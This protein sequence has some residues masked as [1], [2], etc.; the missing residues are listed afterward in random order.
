MNYWKKHYEAILE[1][2]KILQKYKELEDVILILGV[3]ELDDASKIVVKK[4]LQ[5]QNFFSQYFFM[6]EH[7]THEKG[8]YV[9]L[10]ETVDSVV[11]IIEGKYI[12][13]HPSE[14]LYIGSTK[15]LKIAQPTP[16]V[17]ETTQ[18]I[19]TKAKK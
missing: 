15:D 6:T 4:A 7:F 1:T 17:E 19:K 16:I 5:L 2:K 18:E 8:Q 3:D 13:V 9:P 10:N 14:F 12:D 11:E